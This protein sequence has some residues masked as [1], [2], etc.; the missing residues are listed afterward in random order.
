MKQLT[1]LALLVLGMAACNKPQETQNNLGEQ[2]KAV[3]DKFLLA[4]TAGDLK[5]AETLMAEDFKDYGA[6]HSDSATKSQY[7]DIWKNNWEQHFSA[8]KYNRLI[9]ISESF[10]EGPAVGDWVLEWGDANATYKNGRLPVTFKWHGVF[11]VKDGKVNLLSEFFN[12]ADIMGQ[13]GWKFVSPEEQKKE[14]AAK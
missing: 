5:T 3:V 7:L 6:S 10:K 4:M 8:I 12:V 1:G 14:G 2:N 11:R 13:Q 9:A